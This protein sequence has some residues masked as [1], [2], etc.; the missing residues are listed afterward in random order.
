VKILLPLLA[1]SALAPAAFAQD[2]PSAAPAA[3]STSVPTTPFFS[4]VPPGH[5]AFAAVQKLAAAGII[6]GVPVAPQTR[7][8]A[9][10]APAPTKAVVK[11][12]HKPA[13]K[14]VVKKPVAAKVKAAR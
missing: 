10:M 8:V 5:W 9:Q 3:S 1:L 2:A 11:A 12:A 13:A 6:E 7:V 4:D 14:V